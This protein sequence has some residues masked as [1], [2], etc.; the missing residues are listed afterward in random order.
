MRVCI[1]CI[2]CDS[3]FEI[4]KLCNYMDL[5]YIQFQGTLF[6]YLDSCVTSF[7]KRLLRSWICHPLKDVES[8]NHRLNVVENLMARSDIVV[9]AAQ[10]LHKLPDLERLLGRV[11]A[12]VQA[13]ASLVLPLI[14]KKILKQQVSFCK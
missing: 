5:H 1:S 2:N 8:I 6:K 10:Q 12:R 9:V 7:G 3:K 11:K 13:A 14:G 4:F